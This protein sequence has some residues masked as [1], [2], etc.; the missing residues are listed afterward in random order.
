MRSAQLSSQ[1]LKHSTFTAVSLRE[2]EDVIGPQSGQTDLLGTTPLRAKT[3]EVL[4]AEPLKTE[5]FWDVTICRWV[6]ASPGVRHD[7][8]NWTELLD[9]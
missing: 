7:N 2:G 6:T 4:I 1:L 8:K 3:F 9:G 5:V